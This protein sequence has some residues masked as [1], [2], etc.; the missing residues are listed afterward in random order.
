MRPSQP[1]GPVGHRSPTWRSWL[2]RWQRQPP[3]TIEAINHAK[4][5]DIQI[6]V[7]GNKI[8]KADINID[9]VKQGVGDPRPDSRGMG[10][11]NG[12]GTGFR[13]N[14]PSMDELLKW[15]LTADILDLQSQSGQ[16]G[17]GYRHR[18]TIGSKS[19]PGG[20][21]P[22][23][24]RHTQHRRYAGSRIHYWQCSCHGQ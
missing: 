24:R 16:A 12:Y 10:R 11:N 9:R 1:C 5:A 13:Q 15:S 2:S 6:I 22:R 18:S 8:D 17:Q 14:R 3:Q 7:A 20:H 4:A 21:C 23:A 19:R